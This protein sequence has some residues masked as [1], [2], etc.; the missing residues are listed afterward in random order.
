LSWIPDLC[1]PIVTV[2]LML[3]CFCKRLLHVLVI[4]EADDQPT[5]LSK[6]P[7]NFYEDRHSSLFGDV[8]FGMVWCMKLVLIN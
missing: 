4:I 1:H 6:T 2:L 5:N 8:C 7:I 3:P